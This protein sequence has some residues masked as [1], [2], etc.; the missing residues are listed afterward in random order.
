MLLSRDIID[1]D[2]HAS[3]ENTIARQAVR[4]ISFRRFRFC[5]FHSRL[6]RVRL[7]RRQIAPV[8]LG[9]RAVEMMLG[10]VWPD[11]GN[12]AVLSA[13]GSTTASRSEGPRSKERILGM[14][15]LYR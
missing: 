12:E 8:K 2:P 15:I 5:L 10:N 1:K 7:R 13:A 11:A 4:V 3:D 14:K 9:V 6:R